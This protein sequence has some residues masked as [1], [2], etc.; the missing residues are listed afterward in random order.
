MHGADGQ[1]GPFVYFPLAH[2]FERN[3]HV[4]H[5]LDHHRAGRYMDYA[6]ATPEDIAAA[7]AE[8]LSA[9][10]DYRA[11]ETDGAARAAALISELL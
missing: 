5:R 6:T 4:R 1:P 2:H 7:M 3:F 10:T 9:S 11:V 8:Q